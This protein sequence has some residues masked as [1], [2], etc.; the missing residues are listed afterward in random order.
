MQASFSKLLIVFFL[1]Y[2]FSSFN[3]CS[4]EEEHAPQIA[5]YEIDVKLDTQEKKLGGKEILTFINTSHKSIDTLFLHLYPNAFQS[6][7]TTL[8]KESDFSDRIKRRPKYR[9]FMKIEMVGISLGSDLTD[10]KII[11]ETIMKLP[12]PNS[13]PP[14]GKI[15]LE[16]GF[17]VELPRI[18][19][20]MGYYGEDFMISQWFPKMAVLGE[21]GNWNAHQY[22]FNGEFFANFGT[23]DV[24]ITVPLEY[25]IGATGCLVKEYKNTDSTKTLVF[26][27]EDVHDFAW[28]ASPDYQ[29]SKRVVD[30]IEVNFFYKPEHEKAMDRIM[31]DAEFALKY[32]NSCFGK[33]HYNH[34]TMVDTKI[35]LGGGAMEYP[36]LITIFPSR[37]PPEN[38][39]A[40]ALIVFHEIAHQWWYG[41]VASN[42]FEEA[43][44]DEGF[45]VYSQRRALEERFGKRANLID[46]W[47]IKLS[48]LDFTRLS[49]FLDLQSDP[50]VKN[51]W[52]FRNYLSYRANV[53]SKTSLILETLRNY[54]GEERMDEFLKEYFRRYK[55]KHPKTQDFIQVVGEFTGDNLIFVLEQ[56]LFGTGVCDYEVA[57]IESVPLENEDKRRRY[58]TRV[59]VRRLGE[60]VIPV[61]VLIELED[62]GRIKH[63][64][65]G[66]E[67]WHEIEIETD[68]KIRSAVVDPE[69]K[70]ALDI[71]VNNN[72]LTAKSCDSVMMKL[73]TQCLFWLEIWMHW[74][75]CL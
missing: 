59:E 51:S 42:E 41:M 9:G 27:A 11:D 69:N 37:V 29:L 22:H 71:N 12:L 23:Y 28:A 10:K 26:R 50:I 7:T 74:I 52:E 21:D 45:A 35:G 39:R 48:D 19:V 61:D 40:D 25:V 49:Y 63:T 64:W 32:Y 4:S 17:E 60:V 20:R 18:F 56:L 43:W 15:K 5:S 6:N 47:G 36:T 62:G 38:I 66:K 53:Y 1:L 75:T 31:D 70:L 33:Y 30:G 72:S 13:L 16:I 68:S 44:L 65:D 55:F 2:S 46:L 58:R 24:S 54:L 14:R 73:S 67:R 8:M 34:F 3:I 57:S